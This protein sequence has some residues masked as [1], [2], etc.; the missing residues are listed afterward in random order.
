MNPIGKPR[1][2]QLVG[3][4]R[5]GK[6]VFV[7]PSQQAKPRNAE[8]IYLSDKFC[9]A[10]FVGGTIVTYSEGCRFNLEDGR[11]EVAKVLM[12]N[13][14]LGI[15]TADGNVPLLCGML[16]LITFSERKGVFY[17]DVPCIGCYAIA[18]RGVEIP[19]KE[20]LG[21]ALA[22]SAGLLKEG[23]GEA[24]GSK[25]TKAAKPMTDLEKLRAT[26]F[27]GGTLVEYADGFSTEFGRG[28]VARFSIDG[29]RLFIASDG[30]A[31]FS[32]P[33][34]NE[35]RIEKRGD[36]FLIYGDYCSCYALAPVGVEI[37]GR[38]TVDEV[39]DAMEV[40]AER[41]E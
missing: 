16:D 37:P 6:P 35:L 2:A 14:G 33:D 3:L 36:V 7:F 15:K 24:R 31:M 9:G 32:Y 17:L 38:P 34:L 5:H 30:K 27:A 23:M 13:G 21:E 29:D 41:K 19:K 28:R 25:A 10:D 11:A 20:T 22:A 4:T 39:R 40:L 18:P 26:D 1:E 12:E 8:Q